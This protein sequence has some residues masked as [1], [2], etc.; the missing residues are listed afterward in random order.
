MA[1]VPTDPTGISPAYLVA[2]DINQLI[3]VLKNNADA[4]LVNSQMT[5]TLNFININHKIKH[6][7]G[8]II[9]HGIQVEER[10]RQTREELDTLTG[11][12]KYLQEVTNARER[13]I[14]GIRQRLIVCQNERNGIENERNHLVNANHD[15]ANQL[16]D[17]QVRQRRIRDTLQQRNNRLIYQLA[18][19]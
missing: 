2:I 7:I 5:V 16:Q 1:Y 10:A 15:Q 19:K 4:L 12:L 18:I 3:N 9:A 8:L 6:I 11:L 17:Q 14:H 13:E